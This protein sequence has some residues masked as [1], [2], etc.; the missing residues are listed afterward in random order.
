M[1][2]Y[3]VVDEAFP[4]TD[5]GP[6]IDYYEL[7]QVSPNCD[8]KALE[9]AY[10]HLAKKYHPDR[11]GPAHTTKFNQVIEAY[12]VL[13]SPGKR[14]EYN[15]LHAQKNGKAWTELPS[16]NEADDE[17]I[18]LSDADAHDKILLLLYKR[19]REHA[20]NAGVGGFY[21]QEMLNCSDEQ[22][23]FHQWYLKEKGFIAVTEQGT[24]AI[25]IQ[26]VDHVISM[27]RT[28]SVEKLLIAQSRNHP[29]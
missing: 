28:T 18:A 8:E 27:S 14:T 7:L 15:R 17:K 1:A 24:L 29:D 21:I 10:R 5:A 22:F 12:R 26:G 11:S 20:Q 9:N 4:M 25:T 2:A 3:L 6:F 19:R 23:E 13:R 16:S